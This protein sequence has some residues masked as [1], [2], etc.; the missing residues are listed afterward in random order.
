MT[1][2]ERLDSFKSTNPPPASL[3]FTDLRVHIYGD[4]AVLTGHVTS[5]AGPN[6][7]AI[8]QRAIWV[9]ANQGAAWLIVAGQ[10]TSVV[11]ARPEKKP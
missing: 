2:A 8:D 3:D 6:G 9:W 10:S 4:T 1:K 7:Q 11:A 5:Q